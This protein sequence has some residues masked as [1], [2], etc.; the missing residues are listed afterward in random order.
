MVLGEE[1]I[2]TRET[3]RA[4]W[5]ERVRAQRA[6]GKSMTAFCREH[7]IRARTFFRWSRILGG[8]S[9]ALTARHEARPRFA[10]VEFVRPAAETVVVSVRLPCGV[11]VE[12]GQYP[13]PAWVRA[14]ISG[15]VEVGLR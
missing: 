11:S 7:G 5:A 14:V 8:K 13:D 15:L 4:R 10:R 1:V 6:S 3:N 2:M 12:A 9:V